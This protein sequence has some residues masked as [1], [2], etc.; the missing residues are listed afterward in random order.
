MAKVFEE[1]PNLLNGSQ[2]QP[3]YALGRQVLQAV[4]GD[5]DAVLDRIEKVT[6]FT[7][8]HQTV[9]LE[10]PAGADE[11]RYRT[12]DPEHGLEPMET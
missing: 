3:F 4:D 8:F 7:E 2:D 11:I 1:T 9:V 6:Q 12:I 10:V 5:V